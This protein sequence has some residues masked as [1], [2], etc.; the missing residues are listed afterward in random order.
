MV[1]RVLVLLLLSAALF[2]AVHVAA[3]ELDIYDFT[4]NI[5]EG[6]GANLRQLGSNKFAFDLEHDTDE[7]SPDYWFKFKIVRDAAGKTVTFIVNM[8]SKPFFSY[9]FLKPVHSYNGVDWHQ[10]DNRVYDDSTYT[11]TFTQSFTQDSVTVK[12]YVESS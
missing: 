2:P 4:F 1:K 12:V 11:F 5:E 3:G 8:N 6:A 7:Y 10:I 9:A